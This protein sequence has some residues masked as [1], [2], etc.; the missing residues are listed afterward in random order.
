[1]SL[2]AP[3]TLEIS[4]NWIKTRKVKSQEIRFLIRPLLMPYS[5]GVR[6]F[7]AYVEDKPVGFIFFDP[8]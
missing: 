5:E 6:S 8:I 2:S 1:M 7:Y 4:E 3:T